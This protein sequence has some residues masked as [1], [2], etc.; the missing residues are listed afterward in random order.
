M[1]KSVKIRL[2][3]TA[4]QEILMFKS[5]GVSRFAYNWGLAKW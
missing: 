1:I 2:L 3:P 4:Q 5:V